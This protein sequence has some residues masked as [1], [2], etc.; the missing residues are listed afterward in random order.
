M[1][2]VIFILA[3]FAYQ[4]SFAQNNTESIFT[5]VEV[6]PEFPGGQA[7]MYK[8]LGKSI[9]Y[10]KE[11]QK[12]N[13]SGRVFVRFIVRKDGTIDNVEVLKGIGFGCDAE[14]ARVIKAMLKW[15]P[16]YQGGRPVDVFYNLPIVYKLEKR[17]KNKKM[18]I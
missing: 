14:A 1:K 16:G 4:I 2:T 7:E 17:G 12:A 3:I 6:E 5:T 10:P 13:I 8:Y 18:G 11:A 9:I 15:T